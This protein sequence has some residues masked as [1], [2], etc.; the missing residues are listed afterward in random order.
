MRSAMRTTWTSARGRDLRSSTR[1]SRSRL[2]MQ[3]LLK[4]WSVSYWI[5]GYQAPHAST[6]IPVDGTKTAKRDCDLMWLGGYKAASHDVYVGTSRRAV[7]G[8]T[9]KTSRGAASRVTSNLFDPGRLVPRRTYYWR[10]DA[11]GKDGDVMKGQV[12]SFT[13]GGQ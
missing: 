11:V 12:W 2:V 3:I 4:R 13:V 8:A 10:V 1:A 9:R 5:P 6:P 7:A